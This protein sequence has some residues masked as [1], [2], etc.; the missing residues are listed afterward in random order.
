LFLKIRGQLRYY[1]KIKPEDRNTNET[2]IG[3]CLMAI[4][5]HFSANAKKPYQTEALFAAKHFPAKRLKPTS[6]RTTSA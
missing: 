5:D 6:R 3:D 4:S 1:R 2:G